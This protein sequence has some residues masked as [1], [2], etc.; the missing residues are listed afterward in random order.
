MAEKMLELKGVTLVFPPGTVNEKLA[1]FELFLDVAP[2]EWVTVIGGNGAGK[3][4]LL[5]VVSGVCLPQSGRVLLDGEDVTAKKEYQRAKD[6]GRVFQDPLMGTAPNMTVEENLA[7]AKI[8]GEKRS[9]FRT[10]VKRA[11]SAAFEEALAGLGL[12]LETRK[13]TA[14]GALSGGQ[15]QALTLLMAALK[16]PKLLLLDEHTAAL[17]PRTAEKVMEE[18]ESIVRKHQLT[19]LM[20]THNM[21]DA[22]RYGD[23]LIMMERGRIALDISGEEKRQMTVEKLLARFEQ[24]SGSRVVNDKLVL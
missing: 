17:D 9:S 19:T 13:K 5:N 24:E 6:I 18:T 10:G 4:T 16:R 1:L 20:I 3:T 2:G 8:R 14:V 15:R 12:G 11:D 23:R 7:M 22:L 21:R